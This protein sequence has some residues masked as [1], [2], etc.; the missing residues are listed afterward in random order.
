MFK[1]TIALPANKDRVCY[2][3][4]ITGFKSE[5]EAFKALCKKLKRLTPLVLKGTEYSITDIRT[6]IIDRPSLNVVVAPD[7]LD[8]LKI[9]EISRIGGGNEEA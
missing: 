2:T 6:G 3:Q 4:I 9:Q 8:H 5:D 7:D 1:L